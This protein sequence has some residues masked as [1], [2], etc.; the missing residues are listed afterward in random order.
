MLML[1]HT[2]ILR[3]SFG[4]V[5]IKDRGL[6]D[7]YI[8]NILPDLLPLHEAIS[9]EDTH[10][11]A[12]KTNPPPEFSK[13]RFIHLHLLVDDFAHFGAG[14]SRPGSFDP[15]SKGYAYKT[16]K[17]IHAPL[18]E[19]YRK[20]G[21]EISASESA[22]RAHVLIEMAFDLALYEAEKR[23]ME[24]F[25]GAMNFTLEKRIAELSRTAG[26]FY[27]LD[28]RVVEGVLRRAAFLGNPDRLR[29]TMN[30]SGRTGLFQKKFRDTL[31]GEHRRGLEELFRLGMDLT[32]NKEAFL[33]D[34]K[35]MLEKSGFDAG[36]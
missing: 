26:W 4:E 14:E 5:L 6:L 30:V 2:W 12:R 29:T 13:S 17:P 31:G 8:Y 21:T 1:T 7:L 28:E 27:D 11:A 32:G 3:E 24:I 10:K 36:L 15:D 23:I 34:I 25:T 33:R 18:M 20:S 35:G 16:G 19:L 9:A 22:Y